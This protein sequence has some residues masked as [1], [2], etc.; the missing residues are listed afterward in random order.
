MS[1]VVRTVSVVLVVLV[2]AVGGAVVLGIFDRPSVEATESRFVSVNA[3]TTVVETA[4]VLSNPNPVDIHLGNATVN[5]SVTMNGIEMGNGSREGIELTEGTTTVTL[6]TAIDNRKIPAWWASHVANGERTRLNATASVELP[7]LGRTTVT[8]TA[9][10]ETNITMELTSNDSRPV[11]ASLPL[12]SDPILVVN[13]TSASWGDV[14]REETP[15]T[16]EIVLSNPKEI[17]IPITRLDYAITM[18]GVAVGNGTTGQGY[19][20]PAE[21]RETIRTNATIENDE[22]DEWWVTHVERDQRTDLRVAFTAVLELPDGDTVRV[23]LRGLGY[24]TTIE[25]DVLGTNN[26]SGGGGRS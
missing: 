13:R 21:G 8:D 23:P 18:N 12:V 22:L 19:T 5:H 15:L 6:T 4:L 16:S 14:T 20:V 26:E 10:T 7:L 25:T 3:S 2:A 17:P 1:R 24:T 11:N 9:T